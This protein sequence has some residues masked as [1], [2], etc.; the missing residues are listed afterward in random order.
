MHG[1]TFGLT[2]YTEAIRVMET[3]CEAS[4]WWSETSVRRRTSHGSV[5]A[6]PKRFQVADRALSCP[7]GGVTTTLEAT[8]GQILSQSPTNAPSGRWYLNGS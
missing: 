4:E 3:V 8:Q 5:E 1:S 7:N 6:L 2:T